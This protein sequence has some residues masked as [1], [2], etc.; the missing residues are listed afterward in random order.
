MITLSVI[1]TGADKIAGKLQHQKYRAK[2]FAKSVIV[3]YKAR[4]AIYVH[5]DMQRAPKNGSRLYLTQAEKQTR[6]EYTEYMVSGLKTVGHDKPFPMVEI[7]L[8]CCDIIMSV[9]QTM[10]PVDTGFLKN[11]KFQRED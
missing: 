7:L 5:E 9:S 6:Q 11:S 1:A 10:V 3:G 4:Y 2:T 8:G